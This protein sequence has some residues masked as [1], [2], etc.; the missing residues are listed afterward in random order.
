MQ[1]IM[2]DKKSEVSGSR[3]RSELNT[4]STAVDHPEETEVACVNMVQKFLFQNSTNCYTSFGF[5]SS[6]L[7]VSSLNA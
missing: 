5:V 1:T 4:S 7:L 6:Q 2:H 3:I